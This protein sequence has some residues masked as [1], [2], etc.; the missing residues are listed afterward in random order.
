MNVQRLGEKQL[1]LIA[2]LASPG[3]ILISGGN[4]TSQRLIELGLLESRDDA[5]K[6]L[7]RRYQNGVYITASGLRALADAADAGRFNLVPKSERKDT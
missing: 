6:Q 3:T 7:G 1:Q 2:V 4:R 5:Y